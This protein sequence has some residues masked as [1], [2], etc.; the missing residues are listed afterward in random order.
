ML[1]LVCD[2]LVVRESIGGCSDP[3]TPSGQRGVPR[4]IVARVAHGPTRVL[5]VRLII[6]SVIDRSGVLIASRVHR[7]AGHESGTRPLFPVVCKFTVDVA[8]KGDDDSV[9]TTLPEHDGC[10]SR[11]SIAV[12]DPASNAASL[13]ASW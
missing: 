2:S 3:G 6:G 12:L 9:G 7:G 10:L 13:Q 11:E 8:S 4:A 1:E 5:S